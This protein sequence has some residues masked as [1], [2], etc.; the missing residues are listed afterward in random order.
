MSLALI[1]ARDLELSC[2]KSVG[3]RSWSCT[4][5]PHGRTVAVP[6][7]CWSGGR[8]YVRIRHARDYASAKP[9]EKTCRWGSCRGGRISSGP[10]NQ[11][12]AFR[13]ETGQYPAKANRSLRGGSREVFPGLRES[14]M[15][16]MSWRGRTGSLTQRRMRRASFPASLDIRPRDVYRRVSQT[17]WPARGNE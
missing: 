9:A 17:G 13:A 10:G 8:S 14:R 5:R 4:N 2:R 12:A 7:Q 11:P 1:E 3:R 6:P 15:P 16:L